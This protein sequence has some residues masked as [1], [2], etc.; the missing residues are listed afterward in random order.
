MG[1]QVPR[2]LFRKFDSPFHIFPITIADQLRVGGT[3]VSWTQPHVWS[4]LRRFGLD[5]ELKQ[6]TGTSLEINNL[7]HKAGLE[8][9]A[10][11]YLTQGAGGS[12]EI[13]EPVINNFLDVDTFG[14]SKI[15]SRPYDPGVVPKSP[16][17]T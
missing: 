5:R 9:P 3:W 2:T 16:S 7:F 8:T 6:S 15:L 10:K 13:M 12:D 17:S 4:E 14:G 11:Q 1:F